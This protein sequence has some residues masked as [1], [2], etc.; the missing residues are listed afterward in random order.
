M[1]PHILN[2]GGGYQGDPSD[3]FE[4]YNYLRAFWANG[5]PITF[6]GTGFRYSNQRTR[7]VFSGDPVSMSY[8]TEFQPSPTGDLQPNHPR[9]QRFMVSSGPFTLI[10]GESAEF[11]IALVWARGTGYLDSVRKLKTIVANMQ[12]A[13]ESYLVSGYIPE[14]PESPLPSPEYVL[15]FDQN[16]P[17][18]FTDIT[19]IRYSLPKTMQVRLS[20]FDMLGR[21]VATLPQGQQD[22]GIYT[23]DVDTSALPPGIYI[24]R[25]ELDHLTFTKKLVKVVK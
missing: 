18:P 19:T 15:G 9:D 7:F 20:V 23:V 5:D 12:T 16:F 17:N 11:L 8:W 4:L 24:A 10:P 14:Q 22:A 1:P 13:P 25:I 21:E 6:G 3:G 2:G